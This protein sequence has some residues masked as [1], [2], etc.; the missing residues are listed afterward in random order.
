MLL[1]SSSHYWLTH[2]LIHSPTSNPPAPSRHFE[3]EKAVDDR[4]GSSSEKRELE[5]LKCGSGAVFRLR[6]PGYGGQVGVGALGV[7]HGWVY[8]DFAICAA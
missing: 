7:V 8:V 2:P 3:R 6:R 5:W 1:N 4:E